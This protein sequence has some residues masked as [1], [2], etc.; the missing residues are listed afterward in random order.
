MKKKT[1]IAIDEDL[2]IGAMEAADE[3]GVDLS[4]F[5]EGAIRERLV[6]HE[7]WK[8]KRE[9]RLKELKLQKG[10]SAVDKLWG[11]VPADRETVEAILKEDSYLDV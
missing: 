11:I 10:K 3:I 6:G 9:S 5:I 2:L 4:K 1:E 7:Y 8:M